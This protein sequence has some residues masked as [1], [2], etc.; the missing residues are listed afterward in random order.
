MSI[1]VSAAPTD[2]AS[3]TTAEGRAAYLARLLELA[4]SAGNPTGW[5]SALRQQAAAH[6][7]EQTFPTTRDEEWRFTD[8]SELL[9]IELVQPEAT[10]L[11]LDIAGFCLPEA[12]GSRLVFVDGVYAP[13]LSAVDDGPAHLVVGN[14]V[15]LLKTHPDQ[16]DQIQPYLGQQ[17][18]SE[19]VFTALNTSGLTDAAVVLVP[20]N[21]AIETPIHLLFVATGQTPALLQ[22][23]CLLVAA[24]NS[25]LTVVEDY[26][27]LGKGTYFTNSV[28]EIAVQENA[29]VTHIRLQRESLAAVH[30]GKTAV[31]QARTARYISTA[32]SLGAKLSRHNL[33]IYQT[34][35]QTETTLNGLTVLR[36]EQLGDTH[37]TLALSKPYGT[38]RQVHKCI[39]D[40]RAHAVFNGK[41][42]VPKAAQLTDAGQLSRTLLLSPK[43]R[44]DTK[45]QLEIVADNVK[46][47][48]GATVGQLETDEIFYLQSRGIDATTA[49]RLLVYA[50]AYEII[51]QVPIAS[52][53]PILANQVLPAQA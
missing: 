27:T 38:S 6:V 52:L 28:T 41:V 33:E 16:I 14:L 29:Q 30:I 2:T 44:V 39:V 51:S 5:L 20:K 15:N 49:R 12:A 22:P 31:S 19:E 10:P 50:F 37:S 24:P 7:Q 42:F 23:R 53:R 32:I 43:A 48:H 13:E 35:E 4:Q 36:D 11:S 9:K 40:D 21:S 3:L 34:G 8:L 26:V 46:C 25:Q 45:P 17:M 1:Q 47:T 18:G